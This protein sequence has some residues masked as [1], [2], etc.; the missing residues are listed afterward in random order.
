[1]RGKLGILARSRHVLFFSVKKE[2]QVESPIVVQAQRN[3]FKKKRQVNTGPNVD[4]II[5]YRPIS[6]W[7]CKSIF[8]PEYVMTSVD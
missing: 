4:E 3:S 2:S 1:L 5:L 7:M 8:D 6:G